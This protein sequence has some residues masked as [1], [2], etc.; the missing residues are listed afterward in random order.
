MKDYMPLARTS[1]I[2]VL[3]IK[4][5]TLVYD[6]RVTQ[7]HCLNES[8]ALVWRHCDGQT[9]VNEIS[10]LI[11]AHY[12]NSAP[13]DFVWLALEQLQERELLDSDAVER[14]RPTSRRE[15]IKKIGIASVIAA[16]IIAS[17]VAPSSVY[18]AGSCMCIN[19]GACL[20]QTTCPSVVNCNP[21]GICAP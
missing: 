17:M 5:E 2:V 6:L 13:E 14:V 15:M 19:P 1:E 21:S 11:E 10:Q 8:A 18:A 16:P 12:R 7:A 3:E 9:T 20:T 4:D